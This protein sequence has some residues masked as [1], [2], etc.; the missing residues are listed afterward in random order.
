MQMNL[1]LCMSKALFQSQI[2]PVL[3]NLLHEAGF[4]DGLRRLCSCA[5][6]GS[7]AQQIRGSIIWLLVGNNFSID[8]FWYKTYN[9][10]WTAQYYYK[11]SSFGTVIWKITIHVQQD[12]VS[13]GHHYLDQL[14]CWRFTLGDKQAK[15]PCIKGYPHSSVLHESDNWLCSVTR[16]AIVFNE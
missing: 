6:L 3:D 14:A 15:F 2:K 11:Y 16:V 8:K 7:S 10:F 5:K 13:D 9:W 1:A 4:V 12:R